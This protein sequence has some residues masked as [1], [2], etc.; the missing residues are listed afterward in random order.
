MILFWVRCSVWRGHN[1]VVYSQELGD[2]SFRPRVGFNMSGLL[3][4][5]QTDA[6]IGYQGGNGEIDMKV[7]L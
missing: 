5:F 7:L 3:F 2:A 1:N 4:L 6:T